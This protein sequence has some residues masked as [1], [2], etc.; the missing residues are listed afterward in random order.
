M[1][2]TQAAT[3]TDQIR[4]ETWGRKVA[5]SPGEVGNGEGGGGEQSRRLRR[6]IVD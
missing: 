4:L 5:L 2:R 1:Y 6:D 3:G